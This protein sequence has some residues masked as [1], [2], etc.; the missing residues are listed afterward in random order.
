[1][2]EK[3]TPLTPE[4][5]RYM[6]EL[7]SRQDE[8]LRRLQDETAERFPELWQMQIAPDQGAF[9]TLLAQATGARRAIE[10][11][12]FTG[13]SAICIARGLGEEGSLLVCELSDEYAQI[14]GGWIEQ[15]GLSGRVEIRVGPALETLQALPDDE[16][17]DFV[18]I[19]ADKPGYRDYYEACLARLRPGGL[20]VL[21]NIFMAGRVVDPVADDVSAQAMAALNER[22]AADDRVDIAMVAIADGLTILRKR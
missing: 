5:H 20:I 1:M 16:A 10:V 15:A 6:V 19:D 13:Y 9:M 7:G 21:D 14:A 22:L 2:P 3:Y 11:G 8:L 18:F 17:Y 4:L 12:T